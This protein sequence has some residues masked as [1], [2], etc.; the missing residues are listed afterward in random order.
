[1]GTRRWGHQR[2][3][4]PE[5]GPGLA[6]LVAFLAVLAEESAVEAEETAEEVVGFSVL[7]L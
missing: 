7:N 6:S 1:M 3:P 2:S 5:I 4:C